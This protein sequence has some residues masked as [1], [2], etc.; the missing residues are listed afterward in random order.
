MFST[1]IRETPLGLAIVIPV[2][3]YEYE[4]EIDSYKG[5]TVSHIFL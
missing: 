2:S 5:V 4:D 1:T 3:E